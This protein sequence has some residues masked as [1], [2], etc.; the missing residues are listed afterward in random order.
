VTSKRDRRD[1][2]TKIVLLELHLKT[3]GMMKEKLHAI[4]TRMKILINIDMMKDALFQIEMIQV[5]ILK[6]NIREE[7]KSVIT[8]V[9]LTK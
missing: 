4:S 5:D 1:I 3:K 7:M 9:L 2:N 6:M 8:T